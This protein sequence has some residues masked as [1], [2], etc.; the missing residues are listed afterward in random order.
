[1]ALAEAHC[2]G[3]SSFETPWTQKKVA[4]VL[5]GIKLKGRRQSQDFTVDL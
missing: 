4:I 1:M 5:Q 3:R 2:E